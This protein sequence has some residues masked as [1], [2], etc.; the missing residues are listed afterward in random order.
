MWFH[1]VVEGPEFL[2]ERA[3]G[4]AD[5][6]GEKASMPWIESM[7]LYLEGGVLA[8]AP[9][10][11]HAGIHSSS[12]CGLN[13]SASAA[14]FKDCTYIERAAVAKRHDQRVEVPWDVLKDGCGLLQSPWAR[15][16]VVRNQH[17]G[18]AGLRQRA[19]RVPAENQCV[20]G[21]IRHAPR[22]RLASVALQSPTWPV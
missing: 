2:R 8:R 9:Q 6:V 20:T 1:G 14:A 22:R 19:K 5:Q 16:S 21:M 18:L 3:D 17:D 15:D 13:A 12:V 4:V 10:T 7:A 11:P